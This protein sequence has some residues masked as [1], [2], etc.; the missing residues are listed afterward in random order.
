MSCQ[1]PW[2]KSAG[3]SPVKT[4][5]SK[6]VATVSDK[7]SKVVIDTTGR[8]KHVSESFP[9]SESIYV[10]DRGHLVKRDSAGKFYKVDRAGYRIF[11]RRLGLTICLRESGPISPAVLESKA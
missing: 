7:I 3:G 1:R 5:E 10:D 6:A 2:G 9:G 11:P 8:Y 4:E